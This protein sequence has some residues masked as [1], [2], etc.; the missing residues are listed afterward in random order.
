MT[1]RV[2]NL[3]AA[4]AGCCCSRFA[5]RLRGANNTLQDFK[6]DTAYRPGKIRGHMVPRL[7]P[8]F[9]RRRFGVQSA[10]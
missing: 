6:N 10:G 3:Y 8:P 2:H 5:N 9:F 1:C 7:V 4:A